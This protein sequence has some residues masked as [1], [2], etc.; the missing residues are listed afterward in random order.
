VIYQPLV[1]ALA[2]IIWPC[3]TSLPVHSVDNVSSQV[4]PWLD[5]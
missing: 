5:D 3:L 4:M 2:L 1:M